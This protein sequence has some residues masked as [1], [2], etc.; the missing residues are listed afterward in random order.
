M[1]KKYKYCNICESKIDFTEKICAD[2]KKFYKP[3]SSTHKEFTSLDDHVEY[4][5]KKWISRVKAKKDRRDVKITPEYLKACFYVG[6]TKYPHL[7][8]EDLNSPYYPSVDRI[9]SNKDYEE[10][11]IE[12]VYSWINC[13]KGTCSKQEFEELIT[14]HYEYIQARQLP[15]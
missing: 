15:K 1:T 4:W 7:S 8:F 13:A 12:V 14:E 2:C 5:S 10:G 11:N 3:E 6:Q 9:D